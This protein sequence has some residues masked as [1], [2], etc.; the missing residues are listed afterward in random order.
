MTPRDFFGIFSAFSS[1][2]SFGLSIPRPR[3]L[4]LPV[5]SFPYSILRPRF[6]PASSVMV[7]RSF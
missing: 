4:T 7:P 6:L 3:C 1:S 5:L 2:S